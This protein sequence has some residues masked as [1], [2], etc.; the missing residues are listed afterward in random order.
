MW[1]RGRCRNSRPHPRPRTA[2]S[3]LSMHMRRLRPLVV[4]A[5]VV[6]RAGVVLEVGVVAGLL[7]R[8]A[9]GR[10]V[11]E[12]HLEQVQAGIVE[13]L[14]EGERRVANPLRKGSLKVGVGGDTGPD[15]FSWSAEQAVGS[16]VSGCMCLKMS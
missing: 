14:A 16:K 4:A 9:A 12:H 13:V 15:V 2:D 3:P 8:D 1:K 6:L 7:G 5:A 10:V 11:D